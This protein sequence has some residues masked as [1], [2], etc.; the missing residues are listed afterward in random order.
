MRI[1]RKGHRF[2][3]GERRPSTPEYIA[4]I[5]ARRRC[6]GPSRQYKNWAGRGIKFLFKSY[7]EFL[8]DVGRK[9]S[10]KHVLD[11]ID[12]DGHYQPGNLRWTTPSEST[13]NRRMTP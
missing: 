11:R 9:P 10:P 13:E 7:K 1:R 12:N 3:H 2:L 4:Y 8:A 6:F 5:N